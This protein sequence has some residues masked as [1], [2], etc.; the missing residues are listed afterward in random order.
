MT[1]DRRQPD[2]L[3]P[4]LASH[5]A[6]AR[7]AWPS[8]TWDDDEYLAWLA[9]ADAEA[10]ARLPT[11][12]AGDVVL[13]WAA[14]R[15]DAVAHRLFDQHY[16]PAIEPALR[17][18]AGGAD[19]VDEVT[20]RV[21][22][23]LLVGG[24]GR[25]PAITSYA[26]GGS[27]AGLVRVAAVREAL[28]LQRGQRPQAPVEALEDVAGER[29]PELRALK[30]RHAADFQRAFTAAVAALPARDRQLLRLHLSMGASIDDLAR[31]HGT[32]RATA[33][34]WLNAARDA[35]AAGTRRALQAM[36]GLGETE[37]TSLL[38]LVRTE[39]GR[40]LASIPPGDDE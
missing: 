30:Q 10:R 19:L 23:K 14:G 5:L 26:F 25:P 29:D 2:H 12:P 32:H 39:A 11:L 3:E 8:L 34:R 18:F 38:R 40:L 15:G 6:A 1:D 20:Q 7:A 17:R 28:S 37:L 35:L 4:E 9:T 31:I 36:L 13:C 33:A 27:L 24:P 16:L 21:R 22:I